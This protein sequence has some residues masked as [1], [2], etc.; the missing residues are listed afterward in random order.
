[1]YIQIEDIVNDTNSFLQIWINHV[2][3]GSIISMY[4]CLLYV[5][6][7]FPTLLLSPLDAPT[8]SAGISW[9][10]TD[11]RCKLHYR[12]VISGAEDQTEA[13]SALLG[14]EYDQWNADSRNSVQTVV[15]ISEFN[16][17]KVIY[18]HNS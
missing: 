12:V 3:G 13:H 18:I 10:S 8:G 11:S 2:N 15:L 6:S 4:K 14:G 5:F 16:N 17:N 9:F 7:E 1:M